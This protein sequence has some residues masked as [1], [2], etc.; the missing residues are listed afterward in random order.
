MGEPIPSI[1]REYTHARVISQGAR[2]VVGLD[3]VGR[4]A[5]AGPLVAAAVVFPARFR[6]SGLK[7][8][9]LLTPEA[10]EW[11]VY[12]LRAH[13]LEWSYGVVHHWEIDALGMT[14]ANRL[15]FV[16]ALQGLNVPLDNV[17]VDGLPVHPFPYPATF[18]LHGD[19][20]EAV[21]AAASIFAKVF[22]DTLMR[23]AHVLYPQYGFYAHKGYGTRVHRRA[24]NT[25]GAT[26]FHR[27]SFLPSLMLNVK[28][29]MAIEISNIEKVF[30]RL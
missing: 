9:K 16:R 28:T 30:E 5:W 25:Y 23:A 14:E 13:A 22:R 15:V 12:E 21:I 27:R 20:R 7:D 10:R 8:S 3:E 26:P 19:E 18:L 1:P 6:F 24:I 11:F 17:R 2:F 29:Q 4:G